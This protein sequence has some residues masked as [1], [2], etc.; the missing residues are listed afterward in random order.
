MCP[1]QLPYKKSQSCRCVARHGGPCAARTPQRQSDDTRKSCPCRRKT[2]LPA[3]GAAEIGRLQASG[4]SHSAMDGWVL[5]P[6][7]RQRHSQ[8]TALYR[9]SG[10]Y[11]DRAAAAHHDHAGAAPRDGRADSFRRGWT[12]HPC[13]E[14]A[15][16]PRR[17]RAGS[18]AKRDRH[19]LRCDVRTAAVCAMSGRI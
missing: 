18:A 2:R 1:W 17:H 6:A 16:G 14:Y 10:V 19:Y 9:R 8:G 12:H 3:S 5:Q 4:Y 13:R 15:G 7:D 11:T